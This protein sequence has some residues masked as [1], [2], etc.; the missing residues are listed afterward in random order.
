MLPDDYLKKV[1]ESNLSTLSLTPP[2]PTEE[3]LLEHIK[4]L[5][6]LTP[7]SPTW[8][9]LE[10]RLPELLHPEMDEVLESADGHPPTPIEISLHNT[11]DLARTLSA[12]AQDPANIRTSVDT[13]K[14]K[15][16]TYPEAAEWLQ[17]KTDLELLLTLQ[18]IDTLS[19]QAGIPVRPLVQEI[20]ATL[21]HVLDPAPPTVPAH[22]PTLAP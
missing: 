8:S 11:L 18:S 4:S 16:L 12:A 21:N 2:A 14:Q 20:L 9:S 1:F 19:E 13:I 10:R 17:L 22:P 3:Q 5:I 7:E 15:I 6:L